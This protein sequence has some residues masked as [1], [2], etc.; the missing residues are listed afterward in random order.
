MAKN[1]FEFL[2]CVPLPSTC[3]ECRHLT[4]KTRILQKW[5]S[6]LNPVSGSPRIPISPRFQKDEEAMAD[7]T[8][9]LRVQTKG[10]SHM[11]SALRVVSLS[12]LTADTVYRFQATSSCERSHP[13]P[14]IHRNRVCHFSPATPIL[15]VTQSFLKMQDPSFPRAAQPGYNINPTG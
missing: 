2:Y 6:L 15:K 12:C 9:N 3:W 14:W 1:D 8:S 4:I 7:C 11:P 13:R 5:G 10:S